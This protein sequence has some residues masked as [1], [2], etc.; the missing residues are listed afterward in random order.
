MKFYV[1]G[2]KRW[3]WVF[4]STKEFEQWIQDI[5]LIDLPLICR[6]FT[7]GRGKSQSKLDREL[8]DVEWC[9]RFPKIKLYA[10]NKSIF[11]HCLLL[12]GTE[13]ENWG[14]KHFRT[15][16]AQFSHLGF[17]KKVRE[18]CN[19]LGDI[20]VAE[21][22]IALRKPLRTGNRQVFGNIEDNINKFEKEL[23]VQDRKNEDQSLD[24][25]DL[26][27]CTTIQGQMRL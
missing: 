15:I 10:L 27:R 14:P 7:W 17:V 23:M 12:V 2:E 24:E 11:D 22:L 1:R 8:V 20:S 18:E 26:M 19:Q 25:V 4:G 21:N 3:K 13:K 9:L 5:K 16:V 6:K